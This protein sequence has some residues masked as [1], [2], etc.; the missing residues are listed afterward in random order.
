MP[1]SDIDVTTGGQ[2]NPYYGAMIATMDWSLGKVV[3]YLKATDDPR[4]PGKKLFE[5]TYIIFSSDNGASEM[6]G[7]EIVTDNF[8]LDEGKTSAK[9]GG[10]RVPLVITGPDIPCLLYTSPSPRDRG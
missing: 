1:T 3:D 8:P 6:D 2:S 9:E 5:T 4:N 10:V 7:D